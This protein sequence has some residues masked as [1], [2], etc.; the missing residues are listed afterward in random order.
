MTTSVS[1]RSDAAKLYID[2]LRRLGAPKD[3]IK[4]AQRA[5]A[6]PRPASGRPGALS[7][8]R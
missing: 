5:A 7:P 6:L 4:A 2:T 1:E 3:V 8:S